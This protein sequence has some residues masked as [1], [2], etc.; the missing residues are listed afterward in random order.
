M[1]AHSLF[2]AF[3]VSVRADAEI[4]LR[5]LSEPAWPARFGDLSVALDGETVWIP[6]RISN[7]E[8]SGLALEGLTPQRRTF[9]HC[10]L[11]R[12]YDG[13][14]RQ[15]HAA[16]VVRSGAPFVLPFVV[17]LAADYVVEVVEAVRT[18]LAEIDTYPSP[19]F[20][21]YGRFLYENP[22]LL[23]LVRQR[24]N[25]FWNEHHRQAFAREDYPGFALLDAFDRAVDHESKKPGRRQQRR[26]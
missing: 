4:A 13:F 26:R 1:S 2:D 25:S 5:A 3:P 10:V 19:Q 7:P 12:H 16:A 9:V 6:S 21:S 14:V 24:T 23:E 8:P 18:G 11:S 20:L 17:E 15:R 22:A